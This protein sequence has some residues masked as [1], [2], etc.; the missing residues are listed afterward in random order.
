MKK[1]ILALLLAGSVLFANEISLNSDNTDK[2]KL[3][4]TVVSDGQQMIGS[5]FMGYV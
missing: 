2:I 5:R 1:S 4:G 3:T